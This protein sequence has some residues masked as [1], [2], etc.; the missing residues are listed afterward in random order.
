MAELFEVREDSESE[1]DP[2]VQTDNAAVAIALGRARTRRKA[3][4]TEEVDRFLARQEELIGKQLSHIDAQMHHMRLKAAG[5]RLRLGLQAMAALVF[6]GV[7]IAV[8]V[9]AWQ[10][11]RA[12]GLV[13]EAFTV[14]ED[15]AKSGLSGQAVAAQVLDKLAAMQAQTTTAIPARRYETGGGDGIKLEIPETGVS[16]GELNR[17]LRGWLG[18]ETHVTG[19][20]FR[21]AAGLT[22]TARSGDDAGSRTVGAEADLDKLLQTTAEAIYRRTQ[23]FRYAYYI[24]DLG[25]WQ[26]SN[27]V[28]LE[29]ADGPPGDQRGWADAEVAPM[30]WATGDYARSMVIARDSLKQLPNDPYTWGRFK[31]FSLG[32][33]HDEDALFAA[34]HAKELIRRNPSAQTE[35]ANTLFD[36]L[37]DTDIAEFQGEF[38]RAAEFE[39]KAARL[40]DVRDVGVESYVWVA[41]DYALAHDAAKA[42]QAIATARAVKLDPYL[43]G[44]ELIF[45]QNAL[46]RWQE[47]IAAGAELKAAA[48][49]YDYRLSRA[50][51]VQRGQAAVKPAADLAY[52]MAMS[53]DIA[54]GQALVATTLLDCYR[55]VRMRGLIAQQAGDRNGAEHWFSEAAR[56]G[57][58]LPFAHVDW[59]RLELAQGDADG[60]IAKAREANRRA[61]HFADALT[62]WGEALLAKG[63]AK[64]AAA[65]F[66]EAD[67]YTPAWGRNH[68]MWGRALMK[69]GRGDEAKAQFKTAAGL[70]LFPEERADLAQQKV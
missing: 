67:K 35:R 21:T 20:V 25:R 43:M 11:S 7:L 47:A 51:G 40:P 8:G 37:Y 44:K 54:G 12:Q 59:G 29:L 23:P 49:R 24:R 4:A 61:P 45:T 33:G 3:G 9:M 50:P 56:L 68:L 69:L 26:E 27:A 57:P 63:D 36:T 55:C 2:S 60:A 39:A 1:P 42:D 31:S 65:K 38:V 13:V 64:A 5:E 46:G 52:A 66:A 28:L 30:P 32:L 22:V 14:P 18:H 62:L 48:D 41:E 19:E 58:S 17:Y 6:A 15:L 16:L 10:A 53:G 34:R 70:H